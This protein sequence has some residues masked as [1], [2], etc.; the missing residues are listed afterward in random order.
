MDLL[1]A[2]PL[3][4]VD[5]S[6]CAVP[7]AVIW[8]WSRFCTYGLGAAAVYRVR[9]VE[10]LRV[11]DASALPGLVSGQLNAAGRRLSS[12]RTAAPFR[13]PSRAWPA[14]TR[15]GRGEGQNWP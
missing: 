8:P 10:G 14:L 7:F 12:P 1:S 3:A 9:G 11:V 6:T 4:F 13:R 5:S 15:V 2:A